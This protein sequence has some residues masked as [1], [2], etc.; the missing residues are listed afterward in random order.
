[1]YMKLGISHQNSGIQNHLVCCENIEIKF[2]VSAE[3]EIKR[4]TV[5]ENRGR[6]I[7][8]LLFLLKSAITFRTIFLLQTCAIDI[9]LAERLYTSFSEKKKFGDL[10]NSFFNF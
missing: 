9:Q 4:C 3:I 2:V 7:F 5:W 8:L 1:M 10:Y 6:W